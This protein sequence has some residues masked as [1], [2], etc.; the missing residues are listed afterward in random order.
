[1]APITEALAF[2]DS[3]ITVETK[4]EMVEAIKQYKLTSDIN[5]RVNVSPNEVIQFMKK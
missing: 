3:K 4:M 5:K 2:F 1:M